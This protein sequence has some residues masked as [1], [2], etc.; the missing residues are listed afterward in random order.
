MFSMF[1]DYE[2]FIFVKSRVTIKTAKRNGYGFDYQSICQ[3]SLS[4]NIMKMFLLLHKGTQILNDEA[5][6]ARRSLEEVSLTISQSLL[7]NSSATDSC[8]KVWEYKCY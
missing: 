5:H 3:H 8:L 1:C 2:V 7:L 6:T 4:F